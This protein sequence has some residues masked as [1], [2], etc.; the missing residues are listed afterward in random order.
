[1]RPL[2]SLLLRYRVAVTL[3]V[4]VTACVLLVPGFASATTAGLA[5]DRAA[6][7]GLLAAGLTVL[8]ISGKIDLSGGAVFALAGIVAVQLQPQI[9]ILPGALVA[10]AVGMAAGALN[11]ALVI[12]A[13]INSLVATLATMLMFRAMAHLITESQPVSGIDIMFALEISRTIGGIFTL[14]GILFLCLIV[15]LHVWLTRTVAGRNVFATGSNVAAARASGIREQRVHFGAFVFASGLAGLAGILQSLSVN[16]GSPTFGADLT[17]LAITATVV[18]GTLIE[19]G[20]GSA[21]GTLGGVAVIAVLTT[22]MEFSSVPAYV[23][24]IVIG[25]ILLMIVALDR[26]IGFGP[27]RHRPGPGA[28]VGAGAA[29]RK[30]KEEE[31][32]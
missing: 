11:G 8:L 30:N 18:G 26:T 9:G 17:I 5:L 20:R 28:A 12:W 25:V 23:Q 29:L 15:V 27:R 10:T 19:G 16:T 24:Q 2:V 4:A 7:V 14:R 1:M 31:T 32:Q 22:G 3:A 13:R 6:S 21:L